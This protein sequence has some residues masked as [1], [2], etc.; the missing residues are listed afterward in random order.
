MKMKYKQTFSI[1]NEI[2]ECPNIKADIK[3]IN[4]SPFFVRPFKINK[5]DR[6]LM[7]KTDGKISF[8]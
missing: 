3:V 8:F 7:D 1:R 6:P 2:G 5:E 4:Q